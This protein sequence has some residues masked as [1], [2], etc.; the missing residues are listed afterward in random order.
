[1]IFSDSHCH[2]DRYQ[3]EL[4]AEVLQQARVKG[5]GVIVSVGRT[6]ES[7]AETLRLARSHEGVLAAI[8]IHPWNA[9][10]PTEEVRRHLYELA[11]EEGVVAIGE[12]G[13]D[14][15]RSPQT[16]EIQREL[17]I[18]ELS[19]ARE[20]GLPVNL[21]CKEAHQ[22][23]MHILRK[24]AGS[25]LKGIIHGFSGDVKALEDWLALGFY[26]SIGMRGFVINEIPSLE[27]A[28]RE[29]PLDRLLTETDSTASG[30]PAGPADVLLV[31]E[32][33]AFLKG[34]TVDEIANTATANLK[35]LLGL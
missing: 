4:L 28:V 27:A 11:G 14:Y 32:K 35:R 10:S 12:I 20:T 3:P 9:I 30:Q 29:I 18:Y 24:E 7:S 16:Q 34:A 19:L 13:L 33:L 25:G 2:L 26:V 21:H 23:M 22:D 5:V 6:L 17:L 31:V 15:V 8:A 1:M